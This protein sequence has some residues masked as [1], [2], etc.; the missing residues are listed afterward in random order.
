[1]ALKFSC[2]YIFND[3]KRNIVSQVDCWFWHLFPGGHPPE[4]A[5]RG[6]EKKMQ[7]LKEEVEKHLLDKCL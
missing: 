1:M 3:L 4:T 6:E 5:K 7:K 2:I